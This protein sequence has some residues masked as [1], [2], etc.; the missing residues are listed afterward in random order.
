MQV[1][2]RDG[3]VTQARA[4][5]RSGVS[6]KGVVV[7]E[8]GA[9]VQGAVVSVPPHSGG[10]TMTNAEGEFEIGPIE[11]GSLRRISVRHP[12][13]EL[14]ERVETEGRS[15]VRLVLK[16]RELFRGRVLGPDRSPLR[17][18]RLDDHFL[19]SPD[20]RF[21]V[22]LSPVGDQVVFTLYAAGFRPLVVTRVASPDLGDFTLE[23]SPL[24]RGRVRTAAGE[25]ISDA[26]V[27]CDLCEQSTLSGPDGEFQL[28]VPEAGDR[29]L[30]AAE[31]DGAFASA[32]TFVP[33]PSEGRAPMIAPVELVLSPASSLSGR[34][35]LPNG[36]PAGGILV[37]AIPI[38]GR[39]IVSAVTAEDGSFT[40]Q[41]SRGRYR[42][43]PPGTP[44]DEVSGPMTLVDVN[45]EPMPPIVLGPAPGW[46]S[47]RVGVAGGEALFL[48]RGELSSGSATA[49][50][51]LHRQA[52]QLVY[53]VR[54]PVVFHGLSPGRY[55]LVYGPLDERS[56]GRTVMRVVD[57]PATREVRLE[58]DR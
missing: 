40:F 16:R 9:P 58:P 6:I 19:S 47:L 55:T 15:F 53:R 1:T 36:R 18:F 31:K 56:Q 35:Y 32:T 8:R 21:E 13:F 37:Q 33:P 5:L 12:G 34:A 23:L 10:P 28:G 4:E 41:L 30:V 26:V 52:G 17:A 44:P 2:L 22:A 46:A 11:P 45:G 14:L 51:L 54:G 20:G 42:I 38:T 43:S 39:E 29:V 57:V 25:G 27:S 48:A 49:G 3:E 24:V 7:D 50:G